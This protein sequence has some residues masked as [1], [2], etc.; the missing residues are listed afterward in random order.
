MAVPAV[1]IVVNGVTALL[2]AAGRKDDLNIKAAFMHVASDAVLAL[3]VVVA[4][5]LI[6]L[7]GWQWLD[8][9]V[10]LIVRVAIVIGTCSLLR[11]SVNLSL[12]AVP[13]SVERA[14][15]ETFL[16]GL[17]GVTEVHDPHIW[18]LG[19]AETALTVH[20]VLADA[21]DR[22]GLLRGLLKALNGRFKIGHCM[23][24][25]EL[26]EAARICALRLAHVV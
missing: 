15:V 5:G 22:E 16:A 9:A 4:G 26:Q 7:T 21:P 14:K 24:Q 18:G 11:D 19:T 12:N 17:A 8:P 20:L 2:F 23:V 1:G 6:L 25:L 13:S 10:S 3:G